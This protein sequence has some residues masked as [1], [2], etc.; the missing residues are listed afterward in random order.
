MTLSIW[1]LA[2]LAAVPA[3]ARQG[4]PEAP[5]GRIV[6]LNYWASWCAPCRKELPLLAAVHRDYGPRGVELVGIS[7]DE[8]EDRQA[9]QALARRSGVGY[10][11]RFDGTTAEM[12]RH[13]LGDAVPATLILDAD[14]TPAFRLVGEL[15]DEDLR[16]RLEWLLGPRAG[17]RPGELVLP[18]GIT[19]E[20][21][22]EHHEAGESD[23]H[24]TGEHRDHAEGEGGSAVPT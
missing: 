10:R 12:V 8:P 19:A 20:H 1:S 5:A 9:A 7:I 3:P 24:G 16:E 13:R 11:L 17:P 6:L 23:E 15:R 2:V 18:P 14:G 22:R 21:F 4:L